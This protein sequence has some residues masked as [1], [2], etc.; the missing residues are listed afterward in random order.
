MSRYISELQL[1]VSD[2]FNKSH[3]ITDYDKDYCEIVKKKWPHKK[4][5][6]NCKEGKD[7][8][9][10]LITISDSGVF[11]KEGCMFDDYTQLFEEYEKMKVD[12]GIIIDYLKDKTRKM[13]SAKLALDAYNSKKWSF[14]LMSVVQGISI[15]EYVECYKSLKD[16]GLGHIAVGVLLEKRENNAGYVKF[17]EQTL[18]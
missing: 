18:M 5:N 7:F 17:R 15:K 10:K 11:T 12:Y 9:N 6:M 16:Y 1:E 8:S 2:K 3:K 13:E 4:D 14:K